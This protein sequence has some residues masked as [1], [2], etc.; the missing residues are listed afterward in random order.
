ASR[1][2][3]YASAARMWR[4]FGSMGSVSRITVDSQALR[5]NMLGDPSVRV[6]DVYVPAGYDEGGLPLLVDLC[7]LHGQRPVPHE[8]ARLEGKSW[9]GSTGSE[10]KRS[11]L[12][13]R[14]QKLNLRALVLGGATLVIPALLVPAPAG[15]QQAESPR[16]WLD[17]NLPPEIRAA[18]ALDA[19]TLDE[20]VSLLHGHVAF[21]FNGRPK[22]N[23]AIGSAGYVEGV[24]RL[25]I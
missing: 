20:K 15:A 19:M 6:V 3:I 4:F 18:L 2:P 24:P 17:S 13:M 21:P 5:D 11:E 1:E 8:L 25:G 12:G 9:P 23:T 7:G 22:P 14:T 10:V 16:V